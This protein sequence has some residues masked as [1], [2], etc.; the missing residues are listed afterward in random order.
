MLYLQRFIL[1]FSFLVGSSQAFSETFEQAIQ[2]DSFKVEPSS[3]DL[4]DM[5]QALILVVG[6]VDFRLRDETKKLFRDNL[7]LLD[8][9][10]ELNAPGAALAFSHKPWE[11]FIEENIG[12]IG[13]LHKITG[14][15]FLDHMDCGAYRILKGDEVMKTKE[16]ERSAHLEE[17]KKARAKMKE[18]FPELKVHTLLMHLDGTVENIKE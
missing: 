16:T 17:F 15:I 9:Y 3:V 10:S 7:H 14:V 6:C 5:K 2:K 18:K 11:A 12:L 13:R 1:A 4:N 8:N